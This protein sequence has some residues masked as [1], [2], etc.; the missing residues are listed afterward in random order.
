M[1][2]KSLKYNIEFITNVSNEYN[3]EKKNIIKNYLNY[4][5]R[6]NKELL[7]SEFLQFVENIMH[8]TELN[9]DYMLPLIILKMKTFLTN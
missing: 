5:I 8:V 9:I 7:S 1:K 6:Y 2:D 4:I 3:V